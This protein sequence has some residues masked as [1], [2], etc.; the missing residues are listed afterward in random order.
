MVVA[1]V[2]M[3]K[4]ISGEVVVVVEEMEWRWWR[5]GNGSSSGSSGDDLQFCFLRKPNPTLGFHQNL[6]LMEGNA[7]P[8]Y[9]RHPIRNLLRKNVKKSS[10]SSSTLQSSS[11]SSSILQSSSSSGAS[12]P[13]KFVCICVYT[14]DKYEWYT[15]DVSDDIRHNQT[16]P[17]AKYINYRVPFHDDD[18]SGL[19]NLKPKVTA[20][21]D[22]ILGWSILGLTL[23]I[24]D[25]WTGDWR[26]SSVKNESNRVDRIDLV[27][28]RSKWERVPQM[29]NQIAVLAHTFVL[30]G[31]FYCLGG[32]RSKKGEL[33]R[34]SLFAM[35]YDLSVKAGDSLPSPPCINLD[36]IFSGAKEV[37][38]PCFPSQKMDL[39][40]LSL[41]DNK[42]SLDE[43]G[44]NPC[45]P[46]QKIDLERP[47]SFPMA[48]DDSL[49]GSTWLEIS[50]AGEELGNSY[51]QNMELE[52]HKP[53]V[54][55]Y[56][57]S[58]N[59]WE[60]L[61]DP[62][63]CPVKVDSIFS[64]AGEFP[65]PCI[66]VGSPGDG[67]QIYQVNAKKWEKQEFKIC[68]KF[69]PN[70]L[71]GPALAVDSKLYWYSV[72]DL[73]LVGYDLVT[74]MWF[75]GNFPIHDHGEHFGVRD[76]DTPP[77]LAHL[78]GDMFCLLWVSVL[79]RRRMKI[80]ESKDDY[81]SRL[82]CMKLRVTTENFHPVNGIIPL[83]VSILS[84]QSY[85]ASGL[86]FFRGGLVV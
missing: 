7:F 12:L 79:P 37:P 72:H 26:G 2:V 70:V 48:P 16:P 39:E 49:F 77:R 74:S 22:W 65:N 71:T 3:A 80:S 51:S 78:G 53:W 5:R 30:A 13:G 11:S 19:V 45:L 15:F 86:K 35:A 42:S 41:R 36:E 25:D 32:F 68:P 44:P 54:M 84:C 29:P 73:S 24:L 1:V 55:A 67:L 14:V 27:S 58:L 17:P 81:I 46:S 57:P 31:K 82:H 62:P 69:G 10:S 56:D 23:Y 43:E 21:M 34:E 75:V 40:R 33:E 66:V 8:R 63:S 85:L 6:V 28:T 83:E 50:P 60:S 61:P 9:F 76:V 4:E 20:N 52:R 18:E 47:L 64:A 38:N 59:T